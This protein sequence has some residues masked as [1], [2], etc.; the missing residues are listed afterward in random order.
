MLGEYKILNED[1]LRYPDEFVRHKILDAIGDLYMIGMPIIGKFTAYKSGHE[2][3]NKL[4]KLMLE[5]KSKWVIEYLD[6]DNE[7]ISSLA[8][9]YINDKKIYGT[10]HLKTIQ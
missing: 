3:N 2:L 1:G 8:H 5:Q 10:K 9:N 4:L 7:E 6:L